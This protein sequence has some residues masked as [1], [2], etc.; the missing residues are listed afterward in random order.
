[1]VNNYLNE[2]IL[3]RKVP[4]CALELLILCQLYDHKA[5]PLCN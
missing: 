3:R 4:H 5:D 1:M 2:N